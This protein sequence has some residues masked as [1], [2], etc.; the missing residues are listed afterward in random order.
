MIMSK[1]ILIEAFNFIFQNIFKPNPQTVCAI[2]LIN[3][4]GKIE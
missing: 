4:L 2:F 3:D 1:F